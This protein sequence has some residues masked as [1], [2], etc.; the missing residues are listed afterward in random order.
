MNNTNNIKYAVN[1]LIAILFIVVFVFAGM[2]SCGKTAEKARRISIIMKTQ[3]CCEAHPNRVYAPGNASA[4]AARFH[5]IR[6]TVLSPLPDRPNAHRSCIHPAG[7]DDNAACQTMDTPF[8][9]PESPGGLTEYQI[10]E[11]HRFRF[12]L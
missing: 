5:S 11:G 6:Q 1:R 7:S 12:R 4:F 10:R 3:E 8:D 9:V 2:A